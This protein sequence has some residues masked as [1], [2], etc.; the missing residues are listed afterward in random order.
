MA[1]L[2]GLVTIMAA[3][4][5][6]LRAPAGTVGVPVPLGTTGVVQAPLSPL[7]TV[8]LA[9]ETWSARTPAEATL[10]RTTPVRL[11]GFDGL[12]AIV[13]PLAPGEAPTPPPAPAPLPADMP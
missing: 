8:H 9:G 5:R 1:V 12:V 2:M 4:T 3:R 7:G 11:V 10:D 13:E 6:N